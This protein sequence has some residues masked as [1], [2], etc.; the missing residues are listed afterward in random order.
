MNQNMQRSLGALA[1]SLLALALGG[2][3][4]LAADGPSSPDPASATSEVVKRPAQGSGTTPI[5]VP[6]A[7][8]AF[9]HLNYHYDLTIG[10]F[11]PMGGVPLR[12]TVRDGA[13]AGVE[14][15][16]D[17]PAD[18]H[19]SWKAGDPVSARD[20]PFVS[21]TLNDIIAA[22]HREDTNPPVVSWPSGQDYPTSVAVDP[23]ENAIDDEYTYLVSNV[24]I[25]H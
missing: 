22:S 19:E 20:L 13:V 18:W 25:D 5:T 17:S 21:V 2:A 10:V 7:K 8:D 4:A 11:G 9:P 23:E 24:V 14:Y 3:I 12:V 1:G 6:P 16:K 15:A